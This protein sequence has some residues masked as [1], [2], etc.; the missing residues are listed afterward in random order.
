[1]IADDWKAPD[2][3]CDKS[4]DHFNCATWDRLGGDLTVHSTSNFS[5]IWTAAMSAVSGFEPLKCL[6]VPAAELDFATI[7]Q[8]KL[9]M[10]LQSC[11]EVV[12]CREVNPPETP[13]T[14]WSP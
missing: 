2:K 6:G 9:I 13:A 4:G 3:W 14:H 11:G 8:D 1:M 5:A 12:G 7:A 10:L